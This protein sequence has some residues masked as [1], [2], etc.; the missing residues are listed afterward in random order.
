MF[1]MDDQTQEKPRKRRDN[2]KTKKPTGGLKPKN[3]RYDRTEE[4]DPME[5]YWREIAEF[6]EM[7]ED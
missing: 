2:Q 1:N 3:P 7:F 4:I 5:Q 6:E